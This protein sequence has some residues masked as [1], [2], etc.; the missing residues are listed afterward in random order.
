ML[1]F[2]KR[3]FFI[4]KY[5]SRCYLIAV[6]DIHAVIVMVTGATTR[7]G[8][9]VSCEARAPADVRGLLASHIQQVQV[10]RQYGGAWK[11]PRD[12]A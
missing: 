1:P 12:V 2:K 3:A 10:G 11:I 4:S 6:G 5:Q 9:A 7:G 8:R